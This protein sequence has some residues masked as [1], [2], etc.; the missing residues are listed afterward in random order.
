MELNAKHQLPASQSAPTHTYMAVCVCVSFSSA[1]ISIWVRIVNKSSDKVE[2]K[3]NLAP[4]N[5]NFLNMQLSAHL[6]TTK[7]V[8]RTSYDC[9]RQLVS[10]VAA[11][12]GWGVCVCVSVGGITKPK[13]NWI[14]NSCT[15]QT[16]CF[17]LSTHKV[18]RHSHCRYFIHTRIHAHVST[19]MCI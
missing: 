5:L 9:C 14:Y 6:Q 2:K 7:H 12:H 18:H 10:F 8:V 19:Y 4:F 15:T 17:T 1:A 13:I 11:V 16:N 3:Y